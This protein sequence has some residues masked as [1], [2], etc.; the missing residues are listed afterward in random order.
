MKRILFV[1]LLGG[2]GDLV[3]AL[4]AI[5]ALA[6]SHPRAELTVL[7][8]APGC[9]LLATDPL[10]SRVLQA[11][12][13]DVQYP[14]RPRE[15]LAALLEQE[16]YDIIVSDTRYAGIDALIEASGARTVTNLWRHPP[17]GQRIE[18][19]FLEILQDEALIEPWTT[20]LR[21]RLALK[22]RDYL[23]AASHL[24]G[25]KRKVLLHP[26]AGMPIKSWPEANLI[27]LGKA[28]TD[29]LGLQVIIPEGTATERMIAQRLAAA[30]GA[31]AAVLPHAPLR[32]F[33][34]AAS[35]CDL[36]IGPD[37]GPMRIAAAAGAR[38]ITLF[39]PSWHGR[40]GQRPPHINLQGHPACPERDVADFTRQRCWYA[41]ACPLAP[42]RSCVEDVSVGDVLK[43]TTCALSGASW[44]GRPLRQHISV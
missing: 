31:K 33:A 22:E 12:R 44:W 13:G 36:A 20:T 26:H 4:P 11:Q 10:V 6:L 15:S 21:P 32:Q 29:E 14:E 5:H 37:T 39:G 9:E 3:M 41:G 34:A 7:T 35:Y 30:L 8:F 24:A 23:W 28:L 42:W 40:Y 2:I 19:R 38:A 25:P 27:S 43:A 18:E 16:Q 1:E 17:A